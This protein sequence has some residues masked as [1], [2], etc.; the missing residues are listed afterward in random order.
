[1]HKQ[2]YGTEKAAH[3]TAQDKAISE[4]QATPAHDHSD[5]EA[6]LQTIEAA[7]AAE[8]K[9]NLATRVTVL[10]T[11][12]VGTKGEKGDKGEQGEVGLTGVPGL[13]GEFGRD[14]VQGERGERGEKGDSGSAGTPD[15]TVIRAELETVRAALADEEAKHEAL[16]VISDSKFAALNKRIDELVIAA[17]PVISPPL[18]IQPTNPL[19]F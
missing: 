14:G 15:L 7:E 12:G 18:V 9:D 10:E 6:R 16:H 5:H 8:V 3:E 4:L 2:N 13:N 17:G 1:M 19:V 11:S